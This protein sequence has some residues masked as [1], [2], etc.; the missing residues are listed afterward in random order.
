MCMGGTP[1]IA[2]P[3][4]RQQAKLPDNGSTAARTDDTLARRRA[5][6]ATIMTSPSGT[7]G[8]P[9]TTSSTSLG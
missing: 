1:S 5:L 9:S 4:Q 7:L 8:S 6:W 2:Q 3:A